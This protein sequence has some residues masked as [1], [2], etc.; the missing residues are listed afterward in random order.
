MQL[1]SK[2]DEMSNLILQTVISICVS[3][4]SE[5][6]LLPVGSLNKYYYALT[7]EIRNSAN[8]KINDR[9]EYT[10]D[11]TIAISATPDILGAC[12]KLQLAI[13]EE[14]EIIT[15]CKVSNVNLSIEGIWKK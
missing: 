12:K 15:G 14:I 1:M 13:K 8:I 11:L 10:I 6:K 9:N 7:R 5:I 4:F 2:Q 3:E